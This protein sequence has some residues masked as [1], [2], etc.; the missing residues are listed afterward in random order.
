MSF[1]SRFFFVFLIFCNLNVEAKL[2]DK[3]SAIVDDNIITMSQV[4]RIVN[5]LTIKKS[6]IPMIYDKSSY[7]PA[8]ILK[9]LVNKFLIRSKLAELG[10]TT[11]DDQVEVHIKQNLERMGIDRKSLVGLLKQ[12][13][14]SFDEYFETAREF[15][16]YSP[17]VKR[18][19]YPMISVSEQDVKNT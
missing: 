14:T 13:G 11:T 5:N 16:E 2:L 6:V 3:I 8:E 18:V 9:I 4:N 19:I 10:Y 7:T 1:T 15:L 17:F 12:Q